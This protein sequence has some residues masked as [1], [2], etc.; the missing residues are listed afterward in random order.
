MS[1]MKEAYVSVRGDAR[2]EVRRGMT[3]NLDEGRGRGRRLDGVEG[4]MHRQ[5]EYL[6][7]FSLVM[8]VE[9]LAGRAG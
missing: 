3:S 8:E 9:S 6:R 2:E 4:E 1:P 5:Q 7:C